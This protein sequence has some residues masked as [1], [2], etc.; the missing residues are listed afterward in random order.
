MQQHK[1]HPTQLN[2]LVT[3]DKDLEDGNG[4]L[5]WDS[6]TFRTGK[7]LCST[8]ISPPEIN[9]GGDMGPGDDALGRVKPSRGLE[10]GL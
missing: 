1:C 8:L 9:A 3:L 4:W 6:S 7:V 2:M 10:T 5:G